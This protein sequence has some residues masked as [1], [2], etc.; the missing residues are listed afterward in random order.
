MSGPFHDLILRLTG[1]RGTKGDIYEVLFDGEVIATGSSPECAACRVLKDRGLTG[2]ARF[3]RDGRKTYD[4]L[5][6]I[7]WAATK[8]VAEDKIGVRFAKWSPFTFGKGEE[9]ANE[10]AE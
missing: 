2:D 8:Y 1:K 5:L 4:L 7:G 3:W 9:L 10:H 6:P